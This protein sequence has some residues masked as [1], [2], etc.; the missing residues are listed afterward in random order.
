MVIDRRLSVYVFV[1]LA[2]GACAPPKQDTVTANPID[3]AGTAYFQFDLATSTD[4]YKA[5]WNDTSAERKNRVKAG[6]T[7][8]R[9]A[10][11]IRRNLDVA[12]TF[13]GKLEQMD[14]DVAVSLIIFSNIQRENGDFAAAMMTAERA[15]TRAESPSE[16]N[17]A[18][19][20]YAQAALQQAK[21]LIFAG[22]AD[23]IDRG[24]VNEALQRANSI[25]E[26]QQGLAAPALVAL[27]AALILDRRQDALNAWR[28]F[29]HIRSGGPTNSV[30]TQPEKTLSRLLDGTQGSSETID[31]RSLVIALANS[32]QFQAAAVVATTRLQD[33]L[34]DDRGLSELIAYKNFLDETTDLTSA[35][36]RQSAH[37]NENE[38][39][40]REALK[41]EAMKLWPQLNWK[42][43]RAPDYTDEGFQDQIGQ[44]FGADVTFKRISGYY[45]LHMGHRVA[46]EVI[47]IA[48]YDETA[49]LRFISLD[50][51]V[52]NGYTSWFWDGRAE[53]GGWADNPIIIQVRSAYSD[54]GMRAWKSI[55]DA[56]TITH[57]E[58]EIA[59]RELSDIDLALTNPH[60]YLPGLDKRVR[61]RA[62][63]RLLSELRDED[64]TGSALQLAFIAEV[65]RIDLESSIIAHEG[66]HAIEAKSLL[67]FMRPGSKKEFLAKL[68]E[69][70]FSS[71][72]KLAIGGGI[73]S[74]NIGDDSAHGKANERIMEGIVGWMGENRESIEG[75]NSNLP[76]LP[77]MDLLTDEQLRAIFRS[78]DYLAR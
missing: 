56:K 4:L 46:D 27:E 12:R 51:M 69:V 31:Y 6:Q 28:S 65:E 9:T 5:I 67:N 7:M 58:Q 52:S 78:M 30:L 47:V 20:A 41:G 55:S 15:R 17:D 44:R 73:L 8:M 1:V 10:W 49:T 22:N 57:I 60:A 68:S 70:A 45:G 74:S 64:L 54:A 24:Q 2:M 35:F 38:A 59:E 16:N 23:D 72:P 63:Q 75:L 11:H 43:T 32:R 42:E 66:R 48:Q 36:Y 50:T 18:D 26:S 76:M 77:Q 14:D 19:L 21:K 33:A 61:Q 71:F 40:Y 29:F 34:A 53:V 62:Y 37:G 39:A 3:A 13:I 25:L